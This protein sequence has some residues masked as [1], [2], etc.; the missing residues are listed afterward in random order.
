MEFKPLAG[1]ENDYL[2]NNKGCLK[3]LWGNF[4][5]KPTYGYVNK[6]GYVRITI[7]D[8]NLGKQRNCAAHRLVALTFIPN[9]EN[10]PF[11][12]HINGVKTDNRVENLEW[13]TSSEN[14]L[15]S[16]RVLGKSPSKTGLGKFGEK[17][18]NHRKIQVFKDGLLIDTVSGLIET[19]RKYGLEQSAVCLVCQGKRHTHRGYSFKY[20]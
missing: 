5:F 15:H 19:C 9:P 3:S 14:E 8:K 18:P 1:Y 20:L 4:R 6:K 2:I 7:T 10:K 16:Y 17:H 13:C 11:V 12:N